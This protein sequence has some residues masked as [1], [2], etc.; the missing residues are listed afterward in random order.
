MLAVG[1]PTVSAASHT[2]RSSGA[3]R[4]ARAGI[5]ARA[6]RA[7][8]AE[9]AHFAA[10]GKPARGIK[11]KEGGGVTQAGYYNWGGYADTSSTAGAFTAVSG[12][13]TV[14]VLKCTAEDREY[15]DFVGLDGFSNGSVEQTGVLGQCFLGVATYYTWYEMYPAQGSFQIVG[16]TVKAGDKIAASVTRS[17]SSYTLTV[18]DSTTSGN[19]IATTQTCATTTC[20]D[21]SA[22]WIVERPF[23]STTGYVPLGD[24]PAPF[25]LTAGSETAN[26]KTGT[27]ATVAPFDIAMIDSTQTYNLASASALNSAGNSFTDTW[28][29]SY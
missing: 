23:F 24:F 8:R 1:I 17:G 19:N 5:H 15:D 6:L 10:P 9:Y 22:E 12:K 2:G 16:T 14:Q 4:S 20:T 21:M 13:W 25:R 18:T 7:L 11:L 29:N 3:R 27:I 28:L 26:G